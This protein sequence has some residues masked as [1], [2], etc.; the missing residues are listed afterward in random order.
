MHHNTLGLMSFLC[1][2][3]AHSPRL[4]IKSAPQAA[5][6]RSI[7]HAAGAPA[8]ALEGRLVTPRGQV[9]AAASTAYLHDAAVVGKQAGKVHKEAAGEK[10]EPGLGAVAAE[11]HDW[12]G[13]SQQASRSLSRAFAESAQGRASW[14]AASPLYMS[15]SQRQSSS[16]SQGGAVNLQVPMVPPSLTA[17][18]A[19]SEMV[20]SLPVTPRSQVS[21]A[22]A[23]LPSAHATPAQ[24]AAESAGSAVGPG[25]QPS[26]PEL[27]I[28]PGANTQAAHGLTSSFVGVDRDSSQAAAMADSSVS[29]G[30]SSLS[31]VGAIAYTLSPSAQEPAQA[32]ATLPDLDEQSAAAHSGSQPMCTYEGQSAEGSR[33][34]SGSSYRSCDV[35]NGRH[36]DE[37]LPVSYSGFSSDMRAA[38]N[39]TADSLFRQAEASSADSSQQRHEDGTGDAQ[40]E[41][42]APSYASHTSGLADL[43]VSFYLD[44]VYHHI[45]DIAVVGLLIG[46]GCD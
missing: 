35:D 22:D 10:L 24:G 43:R 9:A 46:T 8:R 29:A 25:R 14:A 18:P 42:L 13:A 4:A 38:A 6:K 37:G 19:V 30:L 23:G 20:Y 11:G 21:L 12:Q 17:S 16:A 2:G 45:C 41:D 40:Q 33:R 31:E 34:H 32:A 1:V 44:P 7:L 15:R 28:T 39:A 26:A 3:R 5:A 27:D 36:T